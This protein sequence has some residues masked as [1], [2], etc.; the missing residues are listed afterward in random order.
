MSN[1]KVDLAVTVPD[2]G[3]TTS[4]LAGERVEASVPD[5]ATATVKNV[6]VAQIESAR[7]AFDDRLRRASRAVHEQLDEAVR[8][9]RAR[10]EEEAAVR[11]EVTF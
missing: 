3:F 1:I 9:A 5:M 10:H 7:A 11:E 6:T 4:Q 2:G 8:H